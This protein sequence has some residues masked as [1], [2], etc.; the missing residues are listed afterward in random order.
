MCND[1]SA[2]TFLD[3]YI[4]LRPCSQACSPA[5]SLAR[6]RSL[7]STTMMAG[8]EG[9]LYS[10]RVTEWDQKIS[11]LRFSSTKLLMAPTFR[12]V[13]ACLSGVM[14]FPLP[15]ENSFTKAFMSSHMWSW[16]QSGEVSF[17]NAFIIEDTI[18]PGRDFI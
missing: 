3:A 17:S 11:A 9:P 18:G 13:K 15:A 1:V 16:V 12:P 14:T 6:Q 8:R 2:K 7:P 5:R 4:P 10:R